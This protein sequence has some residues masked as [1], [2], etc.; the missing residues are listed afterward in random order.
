MNIYFYHFK[1]VEKPICVLETS[2]TAADKILVSTLTDKKLSVNNSVTTF[3]FK[4]EFIDLSKQQTIW[5]KDSKLIGKTS[6]PH[7]FESTPIS[8]GVVKT[9]YQCDTVQSVVKC[10][11]SH[12]KP[13]DL[14]AVYTGNKFIGS[15]NTVK[16]ID[17]FITDVIPME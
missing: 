9:S 8:R 1:S 17:G 15:K 12:S 3:G 2:I 16:A 11:K 7:Q 13:F 6:Y 14:I 5:L 10:L 4:I